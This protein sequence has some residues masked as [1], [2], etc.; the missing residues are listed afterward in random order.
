[1]S[2]TALV[3]SA[4]GM[5]GAYQAG[6]YQALADYT[7]IDMVVGVS[8]GALNGF[9]IASGCRPA[10]LIERWRDPFAGQTL[11]M[12]ANPGVL[13]GWFDPE[14]LQTQADSLFRE[15]SPRIPFALAVIEVLTLKTRLVRYPDVKADHL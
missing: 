10:E 12:F 14:A 8:V 11:K 6:A 7:D 1:M 13:R 2:K 3:L 4:G 15:F 5:F 9:A